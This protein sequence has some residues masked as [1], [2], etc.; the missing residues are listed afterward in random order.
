MSGPLTRFGLAAETAEQRREKILA[1]VMAA[2]YRQVPQSVLV[3]V[4]GAFALVMVLWHSMNR[5]ALM[6]WF[7]LILVESLARVRLAYSVSDPNATESTTA[8]ST[9][10]CSGWSSEKNMNPAAPHSRPA[11]AASATQRMAQWRTSSTTSTAR[12]NL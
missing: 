3:S 5:H 6:A 2:V 8:T 10:W 7:M 4:V 11:S 1:G 12:R 9:T